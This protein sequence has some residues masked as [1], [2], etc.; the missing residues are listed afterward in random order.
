MIQARITASSKIL[1]DVLSEGAQGARAALVEVNN[2]GGLDDNLLLL[3]DSNIE[4]ASTTVDT[5]PQC[6]QTRKLDL[7]H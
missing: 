5:T 2:K 4:Q 7:G 6:R 1:G 3:L